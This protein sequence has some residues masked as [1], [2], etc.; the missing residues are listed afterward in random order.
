MAQQLKVLTILTEY[1]SSQ[2]PG[3]L[4]SDISFWTQVAPALIYTYPHTTHIYS[5]F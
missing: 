3:P 4:E 1:L 5:E 2:L